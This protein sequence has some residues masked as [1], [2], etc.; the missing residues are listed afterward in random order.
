MSN[1]FR[2]DNNTQSTRIDKIID[3]SPSRNGELMVETLIRNID[4]ANLLQMTRH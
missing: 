4:M 2:D 3:E 1:I